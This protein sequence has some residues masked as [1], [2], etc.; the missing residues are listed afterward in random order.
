ML[1]AYPGG[2]GVADWIS[3]DPLWGRVANLVF[4]AAEAAHVTNSVEADC[5]SCLAMLKCCVEFLGA[6]RADMPS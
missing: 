1:D 6:L 2:N 3:Q 5:Y 4:S